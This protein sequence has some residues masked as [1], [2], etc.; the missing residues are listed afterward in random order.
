MCC[1][2]LRFSSSRLSSRVSTAWFQRCWS[3][4]TSF[5]LRIHMEIYVVLIANMVVYRD[6]CANVHMANESKD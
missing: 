6:E 3:A 5:W 1:L 2:C 4:V